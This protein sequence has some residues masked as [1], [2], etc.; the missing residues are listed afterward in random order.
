M[1]FIFS[2][3]TKGDMWIIMCSRS[4][5]LLQFKMNTHNSIVIWGLAEWSDYTN[6]R[7]GV[8]GQLVAQFRHVE[9][10]L[11]KQQSLIA[12]LAFHLRKHTGM[13][14]RLI[15]QFQAIFAYTVHLNIPVL[16]DNSVVTKRVN[17]ESENF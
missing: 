9:P 8:W 10:A 17:F 15:I 16:W 11:D 3:Y 5:N 14:Y 4:N 13:I 12:F 7:D 2:F 6:W 1:D